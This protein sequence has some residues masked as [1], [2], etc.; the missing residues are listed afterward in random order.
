MLSELNPLECDTALLSCPAEELAEKI[1]ENGER[2][3]VKRL[4]DY[5][6]ILLSNEM[7][8][9]LFIAELF[10]RYGMTG[11]EQWDDM[12]KRNVVRVI[13]ERLRGDIDLGT[14]IPISE[15]DRSLFRH[16]RNGLIIGYYSLSY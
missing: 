12:G 7:I 11:E 1:V 9:E 15:S 2:L 3:G 8:T 5:N 4:L 16:T 10:Q 14:V 13:N 6:D